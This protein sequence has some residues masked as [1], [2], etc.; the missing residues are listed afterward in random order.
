MRTNIS[1]RFKSQGLWLIFSLAI[2]LIFTSSSLG[3]GTVSAQVEDNFPYGWHDG[4]Y[5]VVFDAWSCGAFGWAVDPDDRDR[6]VLVKVQVDGSEVGETY[7]DIEGDDMYDICTNGTCRFR[8]GLSDIVS[9]D[10]EHEIYVQAWDVETE[11]WFDLWDTPK[12]LT[13]SSFSLPNPWFGVFPDWDYIEGWDWPLGALIEALVDHPDPDLPDCTATAFAEHPE[14]D[15]GAV[16]AQFHLSD[17][18]DIQPGD[19]ITLTDGITPKDHIVFPLQVTMVDAGNNSIGGI[20][21]PGIEV[22][23]WVHGEEGTFQSTIPDEEGDWEINFSPFDLLPGMGGRVEQLDGDGDAT[24]VDWYLPNT[25]FTIF[26]EWDYIEGYEWPDDTPITIIV[27]DKT[28][29]GFETTSSEGFFGIRFPEGC[30]VVI[31]DAVEMTDGV[32][33]RTH[34]VQNL[35]ITEVNSDTDTVR[36]EAD[37]D[38]ELYTLHTWIHGI[39]ESYVQPPLTNGTWEVDFGSMGFDLQAGMGGRVEIVDDYSNATAVEWFLLNPWFSAFPEGDAVEGWDWPL[40]AVVHMTIDDPSTEPLPD[41]EMDGTV[42]LAPWG[43]GQHWLW[44]EFGGE[45]DMKPGDFVTLSDGLTTRTHVVQNLSI[46]DINPIEN[47]V[48]GDANPGKSVILWS[49]EDPEGRRLET[50]SNELGVWEADFDDIGF[51][52]EPGFHIRAEIWVDENNTA[53]D[54]EVPNP[55]I[56]VYLDEDFVIGWDWPQGAMVT[57]TIDDPET[58]EGVDY[59]N[60]VEVVPTDFSDQVWWARFDFVGTYDVK[61]GDLVILTSGAIRKQHVVLPLAVITVDG[62]NDLVTGTSDPGAWVFVH[63]WDAWFDP[64]QADGVGN[65]EMSFVDF[66]DLMPGTWGIAEVFDEDSDST[67]ID[68]TVRKPIAIDIKPFSDFNQVA[69]RFPSNLIP[70]ALLGA[71]DFVATSVEPDS[72]RFG[73]TGYEAEVV[74]LDWN[75]LPLQYTRDVNRD[76]YTDVVYYFRLGETGFSCADIPA[77]HRFATVDGKLTGWTTDF[78]VEGV[79][80][81]ILYKFLD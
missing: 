35:T 19:F 73:K 5:G 17:S 78:G 60:T 28:E 51:D 59:E 13:C 70:V 8:L 66:Y 71:E 32:T 36:G 16:V 54:R 46:T 26:P 57:L 15:P 27:S 12:Y 80:F 22:Q 65:W 77:D 4:S 14:W 67:A 81:L 20:A 11:S 69:C 9:P 7:A 1:L 44:I 63:P 18:C 49:W 31:G 45:F 23:A 58:G 53:V 76:G 74:R 47:I 68:W 56:A 72:I 64:V 33:F 41:F 3:L 48:T 10:V 2:V 25:R 34:T 24:S 52:L 43:S 38:L 6:D 75:G 29:C 21:E 40:S 37:F 42:I 39:D 55:R 61:P 30:D 79:D 50:T 62:E